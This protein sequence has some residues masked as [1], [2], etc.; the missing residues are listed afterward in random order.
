MTKLEKVLVVD[1]SRV[2]R[3]SLARSLRTSY[4]VYEE[5]N[6]E[7]AW[8]SLVLDSSIV[9][10][11]S[12]VPITTLDGAGLIERIRGSKLSRLNQMPF[13]LLVSENIP[14]TLRVYAVDIGVSGFV[15]KE[16]P[17]LVVD[18]LAGNIKQDALGYAR[19]S[20]V[21]ISDFS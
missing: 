4:E 16:S 6:A 14:E 10:V 21:G 13:F 11:V 1:A 3:A 19:Q 7:S 2:A 20:D 5:S 17:S 9:A 18:L 8:Q 15:P 12:G